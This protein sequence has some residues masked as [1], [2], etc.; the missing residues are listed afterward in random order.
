MPLSFIVYILLGWLLFCNVAIAIVGRIWWMPVAR[1]FPAERW[2]ERGEGVRAGWQNVSLGFANYGGVMHT[3]V[4]EEGLYLRPI[5]A[6]LFNHPPMMIPWS[7]MGMPRK[8]LF[9]GVEISV[10]GGTRLRLR[11][12]VERLVT[13]VLAAVSAGTARPA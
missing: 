9:G 5:R 6:F 7:A 2:P 8:T 1:R 10:E 4:A 13:D 12:K 11:G 3:V